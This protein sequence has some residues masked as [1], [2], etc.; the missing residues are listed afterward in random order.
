MNF[1]PKYKFLFQVEKMDIGK[2]ILYCLFQAPPSTLGMHGMHDYILPQTINFSEKSVGGLGILRHESRSW[3]F[4][5][6]GTCH[7]LELQQPVAIKWCC[8]KEVELMQKV[9][10][11]SGL[12]PEVFAR[13]IVVVWLKGLLS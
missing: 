9:K 11:V 6:T 5:L 7:E 3:N 10:N 12:V 4:I 8:L 13:D 1:T 2:Q